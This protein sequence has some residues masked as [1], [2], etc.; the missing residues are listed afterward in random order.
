VLTGGKGLRAG[1]ESLA[2]EAA[3][4]EPGAIDKL[5]NRQYSWQDLLDKASKLDKSA[6]FK[7]FLSQFGGIVMKARD[8]E[9]GRMQRISAEVQ[10][11]AREILG[12]K[13]NGQLNTILNRQSN[14][15]ITLGPYRTSTGNIITLEMT[16]AEMMKKHQEFKDPSLADTFERGMNWTG[17]I[18]RGIENALT[19]QE[20]AWA[21]W[22]MEFY[23]RYYDDVNEVYREV[24]GIDLP[25]NLNYSPIS[26]EFDSEVPEQQLVYREMARWATVTNGSLK[27]RQR[28]IQPLRQ[29][30]ANRT[31]INHITQMEH[32]IN[33]A[34]PM[35][36]L[37]TVFS[38]KN[39]RAAFIQYHGKDIL[40]QIDS[41]IQD[42][43]R[44]G[45]SKMLNV[46]LFDKARANF[47]KAVLGFKPAIALQQIPTVFAYLT[48]MKAGDFMS[49]VADFWRH[50]V[51]NWKWMMK[52]VPYLKERY[53]GG[54]ER[55]MKVAMSGDAYKSFM[56]K[57]NVTN[58]FYF[59]MSLGDKFAVLQGWWAKYQAEYKALDKA[60]QLAILGEKGAREASI[61]EANNAT[62]R[63]Q[64]TSSI[65]TLSSWQRGGTFWKLLTM[66]Q[67]QPN[68]YFRIIANNMRNLKYGRGSR[69]KAVSNIAL[70]WVILPALFTLIANGF[71]FKKDKELADVA[72]APINDLL[73]FGQ[74]SQTV[75]DWI[76]GDTFEY[77]PTPLAAPVKDIL[78]FVQKSR[79]LWNIADD[80]YD[81]ISADEWAE[82]IE[83]FFKPA[84][85]IGG[86]PTPYLIQLERAIRNGDPRQLV[87]SKWAL[88]EAEPGKAGKA[89]NA[90]GQLGL[91]AEGEA[92]P[93]DKAPKIYGMSDLYT[94]YNQIFSKTL[95]S[96]ITEKK[97]FSLIAEAWGAAAMT[98]D[99]VDSLPNK[100]LWE[101]VE[102]IEKDNS[103]VW[104]FAQYYQ[105]WQAR[106][107]ITS[108]AELKEF[109]KAN[110]RAYLGN[111]TAEQYGLLLEY[112][113]R[114]AAGRAAFLK[115]HPELNVNPQTAW[116]KANPEENAELAVWGKAKI[117]TL[118]AYNAAVKL[119]KELGIPEAA[120]PEKIFPPKDIA[121]NYFKYLET[122][123]ATGANS[124]ETQLILAEDNALRGWLGRDDIKTPAEALKLMISHKDLYEMQESYNDIESAN[125]IADDDLRKKAIEAL[126]AGNPGWVDDMRRVEAIKNGGSEFAELWVERG[127]IID[128]DKIG[129]AR[130]DNSS[131]AKLWLIDHPEVHQWALEN[132]MLKDDGT[133]WNEKVLRITVQYRELD[134]Q[135]E[136]YGKEDSYLYIEDEK[137]RDAAQEQ[138]LRDNPDYADARARRDV[139]ANGGDDSIANLNVE[140]SSIVRQY[141]AG[142]AEAK[143]YRIDHGDFDLWGRDQFTFNW[144]EI[145]DNVNVLRINAK[146]RKEDAEYDALPPD[147]AVRADY[148]AGHD[149]YRIDRRRREAYRLFDTT[150]PELVNAY[151]EY[152]ELPLNGKRRDRYLI[153]H[154]DFAQVMHTQ[155][156]ID[157]P[158]RAPSVQYDEI[159]EKYEADFVRLNGL[160]D[161]KSEYYIEDPEARQR[162]REEMRFKDGRLTEFGLAEIRRDAYGQYVPD[163]YIER[164]VDYYKIVAEGAADSW[165]KDR[166]G[167]RLTWYGDDWYLIEHPAFYE[168]VY[169]GQLGLEERDFSKVPSKEVFQ[170]YA[171]YVKMVTD[172]EK[173]N[174]RARNPDLEKWLLKTGKAAT[175][176][177]EQRR[178]KNLTATEQNA[179]DLAELRER[180][181]R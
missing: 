179:E 134:E 148:L 107:K 48:E 168:D 80:P 49:G 178:R 7:S 116:L 78:S 88:E 124:W 20:K 46:R 146:W 30:D 93:L 1:A 22:Q 59:L 61:L 92:V 56:G 43:A 76:I 129:S 143:L 23:Q 175:P 21:D 151:V 25:H 161:Y 144:S 53:E 36:E 24:Y 165:P 19:A 40:N 17:E 39:V 89:Q 52:N 152:N 31:L 118:E 35:R 109:D 90:A 132:K 34:R 150:G 126:K 127:H 91:Q 172:T 82:F 85:E 128:G 173:K 68:K 26:R 84:G 145:T 14:E 119:V 162:A 99:T 62:D 177:S 108:L 77:Q 79:K 101:I 57:Q 112:Q 70:A 117:Y 38:D 16:K 166:S 115:A 102:D 130:K 114:D 155:A 37:R 170:K 41:Y 125:Y 86:L 174:Y 156:G 149:E 87:F 58:A 74:I 171:L 121:V 159:Y 98:L 94:Y 5:V 11:K 3:L 10:A 45:V 12:A 142:S 105:Q 106:Q 33:W 8:A 169:L 181:K 50:P 147:G 111:L 123:G 180:I 15:K 137:E 2:K 29:V 97:G 51:E 32:F 54:F 81:E 136:A 138:L 158:D 135:Y 73:F 28:N 4:P 95:P 47:S 44:G 133:D 96:D 27:S 154:P 13:N 167:N 60:G 157:L 72:L 122:A 110:P 141:G 139:Y 9:N 65:D 67:S 163:E 140:Y 176:I 164:Y 100:K 63:T 153:E 113:R 69:A 131:E 75:N 64:N 42:Y 120:L 160:S 71:K 104:T 18:R 83:A 103:L 6:P 55:D 66:F